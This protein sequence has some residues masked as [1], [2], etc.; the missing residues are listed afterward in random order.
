MI[1]Y[2]CKY[3]KEGYCLIHELKDLKE[4]EFGIFKR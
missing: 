1:C 4:C 2:Y 3:N